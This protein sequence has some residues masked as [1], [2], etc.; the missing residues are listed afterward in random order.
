MAQQLA[1]QSNN[2][3]IEEVA[4]TGIRSALTNALVEK[5]SASNIKEVIQAEDIG[6]LPDQNLADVLENITGIQIDRSA[7]VG[8]AVQIRGT[9]ANRIEINGVS[10]VSNGNDRSG[11]S[12]EDLPAALIA[13]LEVIMVPEAKTV[14]G[15]VG[16]TINLRTLRGLELKDRLTS[17]RLQAEHTDLADSYTPRVSG[18][19]GDN[20][21]TGAGEFGVV[22]SASY[23]QQEVASFDPRFDRDRE[24][25]PNSGRASA[26]DFP[27]LRT[28]FADQ[29]LTRYDYETKNLTTSFQFAPNDDM[30]FY[31]V[32]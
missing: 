2:N 10:T 22:V 4:V 15:S 30:K 24:V 19:F 12:F 21:S 14:E 3:Q 26:E 28:Q 20:W 6:K 29:V 7:G 18:T 32:S 27:F 13:S 31:F 16:G 5:R 25:L 23:A 1:S 17:V 9:D 11:I 8:T